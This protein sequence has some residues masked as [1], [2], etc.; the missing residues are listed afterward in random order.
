[1]NDLADFNFAISYKPGKENIDSDLLS[2]KPIDLSKLKYLCSESIF[3]LTES[4]A[5][6]W[7]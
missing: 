6:F 2:R 5:R 4:A 7:W 1:M 3:H